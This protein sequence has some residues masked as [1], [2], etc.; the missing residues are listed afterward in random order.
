ML[1]YSG[2]SVDD[3]GATKLDRAIGSASQRQRSQ[4]H[5]NGVLGTWTRVLSHARREQPERQR[6]HVPQHDRPDRRRACRS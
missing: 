6:Q 5:Y 3:T 4:N 2:E 1:R